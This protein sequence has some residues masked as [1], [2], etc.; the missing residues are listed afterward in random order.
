V[1]DPAYDPTRY[2]VDLVGPRVVNTMPEPTLLEV[3]R[4]GQVSGDTIRPF[5]AE[6]AEVLDGLA[7]LGIDYDAVVAAL[8]RDGVE[9]F[10]LSWSDLLGSVSTAMTTHEATPPAAHTQPH[11][12]RDLR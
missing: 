7:A 8:E 10:Q 11:D 3:S 4:T 9:K 6:A 12:E 2:V 1:K 5:Y